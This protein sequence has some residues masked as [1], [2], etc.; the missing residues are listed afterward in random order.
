MIFRQHLDFNIEI[1]S[2]K[3]PTSQ[4]TTYLL[5][6]VLFSGVTGILAGANLS[7]E[8]KDPSRS[9]PKGTIA[10]TVFTFITYFVLFILTSVSCNR[11]LL[12]HECMFM[13]N[14]DF[15]G[16]TVCIGRFLF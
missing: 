6:G 2:F 4:P 14:I 1:L 15:W 10:G 9:I 7:G 16:P 13:Y 11:E 5:F 8:L 12:Y 3:D